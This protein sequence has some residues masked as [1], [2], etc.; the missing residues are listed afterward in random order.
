[1]SKENTNKKNDIYKVRFEL[2]CMWHVTILVIVM[3]RLVYRVL[4]I[5]VYGKKIATT[6]N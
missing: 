1:M 2:Y 4:Y 6:Y 3:I 5:A